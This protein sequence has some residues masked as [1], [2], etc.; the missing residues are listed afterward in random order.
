ML[1][2]RRFLSLLPTR[3][4]SSLCYRLFARRSAEYPAYFEAAPLRFAPQTRMRLRAGDWA[5]VSIAFMGV[6]ELPLTRLVMSVARR[7]RSPGGL[8]VDVGANFGY[9][10]LLWASLDPKNRAL[11]FEPAPANAAALSANVATNGFASRVEVV[12]A[13]VGR[14][15]GEVRFTQDTEQ[16]GW[17]RISDHGAA[18]EAL[19][20]VTLDDSLP[21]SRGPIALLKIDT[22]GHDWAVLEGSR[23]LFASRR[24]EVAVFECD[25]A[26]YQ[27]PQGARLQALA[28][29]CGYRIGVLEENTEGLMTCLLTRNDLPAP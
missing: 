5:H 22:E 25:A 26:E 18:G 6:Y 15:R 12:P 10:A 7:C 28:R 19:P 17:S 2:I 27:G 21:A 14:E 3:I 8:M 23:G 11:A 9:F 29:E 1:P 13:A 16:S 20:L 24:I 4:A